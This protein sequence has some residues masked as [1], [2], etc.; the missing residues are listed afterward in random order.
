MLDRFAL[1]SAPRS[2]RLPRVN[3]STGAVCCANLQRHGI[4]ASPRS[5]W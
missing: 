4:T 1:T 2:W 3:P 5:I